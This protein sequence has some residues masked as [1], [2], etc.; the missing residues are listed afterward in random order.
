CD[1]RADPKWCLRR[2]SVTITATNFCPSNNNGGWCNP[3]HHHFD[4]SLPAFLRIARHGDEGIV[5]GA[6]QEERRS[7]VHLERAIEFQH[8]DDHERRWQ[9][10]R[11][12]GM[13]K[14]VENQ[15]MAAYE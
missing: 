9:R 2:A 4:M 12:G 14:G 3:P 6:M 7:P 1:Y 8:G 5:P 15:N 13:D 10:Q 11:E